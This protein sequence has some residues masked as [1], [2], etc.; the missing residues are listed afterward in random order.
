MKKDKQGWKETLEHGVL[1][2]LFIGFALGGIGY[3]FE[4]DALTYIGSGIMLYGFFRMV[5][6]G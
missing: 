4:I 3:V 5:Y 6:D 1:A 2:P